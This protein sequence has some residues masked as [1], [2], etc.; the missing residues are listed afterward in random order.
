[1]G[2]FSH[3]DTPENQMVA[4]FSCSSDQT[5]KVD[6]NEASGASFYSREEADN[7]VASQKTTPWLRDGWKLARDKLQEKIPS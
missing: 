2:K 1:M 7:V 6:E 4:V 3:H 5:L